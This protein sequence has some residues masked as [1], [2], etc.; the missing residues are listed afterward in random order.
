MP[1]SLIN[2][3]IY[4][5]IVLFSLIVIGIILTRLYRRAT[6]DVALIRTGFG[7]E[8]V[9]LN[10]G[11]MVVPVLHE[12][13]QVR[14]TTVKLE[15]S[16]L[17]KD[18]LITLDKLRVDV[19]GLFHIKVKPDMQSIAAAAQTLGD[20]VNNP[21]AV[22]SLLDG[23]LVSALRSVAATMTM[24]HLHANRADFI[25][26]VQEALMTDLD[27]NGFQL[28]SVSITHFDQ[29]AFEHFNENNAFD[30]EG[31]TVLTRTIE[32]RKKVRNDIVATNRVEIEQRNLEA[33]KQSL[34]IAQAAEQARLTQEQTL[35]ALRAEQSTAIA[36]AEAEQTRVAE[37]ARITAMQAQTVAQTEADK[38][39]QTANISRDGAIQTATIERDRNIELARI[40]T[41]VQTAQKSEEESK[42]IA[43]ANEAR[44]L[45]VRAEESVATAKATEIANRNKNV[46]VIAATQ[47]AQEEAVGITVA[48][49]AEK[50]AAEARAIALK[51]EATAESEA[52]KVRAEGR[53]AAFKVDAAGQALLN[54]AI[55]LRSD[56]QTALLIRQAM[57]EALPGIIA[58][59][60]KPMENID[61]I[62]IVDARGLHGEGASDGEGANG[63][64]NLADAAV[65][66]A[67]R[68]RVG[69]PLIDAL[70]SELGMS[71]TSLNGMLAGATA[72]TG[73]GA[74]GAVPATVREGD[75][76]R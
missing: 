65:A 35:A 6:K 66:A 41:A 11:V 3:L 9:V 37:I 7:G 67:M 73:A 8:K 34:E 76:P 49:G 54:E 29:T 48:A 55:N 72:A 43:A 63:Q 1:E 21:D 51:T 42:A 75:T 23:K 10:G 68:Y 39:T 46:A 4:A 69:G 14:L 17:N 40:T 33:N 24:E 60:S 44:A 20:S 74:N 28:E 45:A 61:K 70:M 58:A 50:E 59:A 52:E 22:K 27:M 12:L 56:A 71:G 32:E 64:A 47:R 5:A 57:L 19:I 13:M 15:V 53:E 62:S 25:Q 31:L 26:K 2:I 18:A 38:V 36:T 16:R 30:A